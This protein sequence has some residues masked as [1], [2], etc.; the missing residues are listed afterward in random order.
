MIDGCQG[1]A[2]GAASHLTQNYRHEVLAMDEFPYEDAAMP[3][4]PE[5]SATTNSS[6]ALE[7]VKQ[8]HEQELMAIDGVEGVGVG[9]SKIGDDAIIV[10]LRDEGAKKRIPRSVAGYPVETIITGI[11]DAY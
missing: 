11:I 3:Y 1:P 10:Y 5:E 6:S 4:S 8:N 7:H 9:R 2:A